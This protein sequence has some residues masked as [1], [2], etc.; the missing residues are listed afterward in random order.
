MVSCAAGRKKEQESE[1]KARDRLVDMAS[2]CVY[3]K[4][5]R[6]DKD[7]FTWLHK[8]LVTVTGYEEGNWGC[9]ENSR[10][11]FSIAN[12]LVIFKF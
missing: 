6:R 10:R 11:K 12:P 2:F 1:A 8:K 3:K 9:V 7:V 5:V 4:K